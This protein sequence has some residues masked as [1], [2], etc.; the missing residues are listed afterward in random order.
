MA[1]CLMAAALI[2]A[3]LIVAA[4]IAASLIAASPMAASLRRSALLG[5]ALSAAGLA[6]AASLQISP[7]SVRFAGDQQASSIS[8]QNMGEAAIYG[9]VRVFRWDQQ[10]GQDV[11]TP[12]RE[13]IVSPPIVQI[14]AH[15]TQAI[16]LVLA[17]GAR[18]GG[19]EGTYRVL[20]DELGREEGAA[21]QG[22]DIRLRYS[23]PV[24]LAPP[25]AAGAPAARDDQ[26]DWQVFRQ[27]GSWMLKV[28][29]AGALHAQIGAA[30]IVNRRG[31]RF[32]ISKGLFG[33]V[34][35]GREREWK[36]A[37]DDQADLDGV[38][39]VRAV[40]NARAPSSFVG[41]AR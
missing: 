31:Q 3:S 22:V 25:L 20:I 41:R 30:D 15:A 11:L 35:A 33:Y 1:A 18:A 10:Q 39:D 24:F 5:L 26:L 16:R 14:A 7:V 27:D 12:T 4:L 19:G 32:N 38:L 36:L 23:V 40:I 8:L 9:Q 29:N 2:A 34:L 28:R 17:P 21:A 6:S 13:V 37:L